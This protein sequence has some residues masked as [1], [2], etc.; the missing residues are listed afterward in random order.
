MANI[1]AIGTTEAASSSVVL[2]GSPSTLF[3]ST[4]AGAVPPTARAWIQVQS[5]GG[6]WQTVG[7]LNQATPALTMTATGTYR[8]Y[9]PAADAAFGVEQG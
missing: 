3:L 6:N 7:L 2:T 1:L 8:V 5:A 9:R 4:T